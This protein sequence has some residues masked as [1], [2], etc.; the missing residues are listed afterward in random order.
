[1]IK[2]LTEIQVE[3]I[4]KNNEELQGVRFV[5][6]YDYY[7]KIG[8]LNLGYC[9]IYNLEKR[10]SSILFEWTGSTLTDKY[11]IPTRDVDVSNL[12][13]DRLSNK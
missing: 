2:N 7:I 11:I 4:S 6:L 5:Y 12:L 8:K 10:G 9:N 3:R 13:M 1:M